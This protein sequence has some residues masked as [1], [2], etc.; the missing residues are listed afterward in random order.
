MDKYEIF[1][2][3]VIEKIKNVWPT[4]TIEELD[5]VS[6][7]MDQTAIEYDIQPK[8]TEIIVANQNGVPEVLKLFLTALVVEDKAEGTLKDYRLNLQHMFASI[9]KSFDK[10]TT[11]DL[12]VYLYNYKANRNVANSTLDHVRIVINAFYNWCRH[13]GL[14]TVNPCETIRPIKVPESSR[15]PLDQME[16]ELIRDACKDLREKALIDFLYSTGCRV[17]EVVEMKVAD[18]D[19]KEHSALVRHGKGDK[20]R[21][22]YLNPECEISLKKYLKERKNQTEYVFSHERKLKNPKMSTRA[23]QEIIRKIVSRVE[24]ESGKKITPHVFRHTT[25]TIALTNGMPIEQVQK[26]LGHSKLDTTMIYAKVRDAAVQESHKKYV[27]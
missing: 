12:R 2:L 17:D 13:E 10:I 14:V 8:C 5:I 16:L 1:K 15:Q 7:A 22:V 20:E 6:A 19:W 11:N 25:A 9:P 24:L 27:T 4:M 21:I 26:M 23:I 3:Q 18:I